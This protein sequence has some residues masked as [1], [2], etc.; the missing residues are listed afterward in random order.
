[1]IEA[2]TERPPGP[3]GLP[4]LGNIFQMGNVDPLVFWRN[5]HAEYGDVI[6]LKL[7]PMDA[8]FFSAPQAIYDVFVTQ[9]RTMRKGIG[10]S[11]LRKLLGEGL[12]TNDRDH[13]SSQRN[14]LNPV[15][16][17]AAVEAYAHAVFDACQAGLPELE[18]LTAR[19]EPI[20]I[21]HA[22]TRFTMRVISRAAFGVDLGEGHDQIVDAFEFAFAFVA[23]ITAQPV[24]P[25]LFVPTPNNR[26]FLK[27][28]RLIDAFID[29]LIDRSRTQPD[30]S[31]MNGRI[32][33]ALEGTEHALFRDEVISLYFAGFETTARTMTF[34]MDLLARH[35]ETLAALR[36]EAGHLEDG[37]GERP[38]S[39]RL[40]VATEIVNEALRIY[41]PVALMARQPNS[42]CI[43]GGYPVRANSLIIVCPFL[44]QR[45]PAFW[46]AGGQFAPDPDHP[47]AS[48]LRHRAAFTPFGGGPRLCLGKHFAMIELA[49]AI[50]LIARD[51]DWQLVDRDPVE[52]AFHGTLRPKVPVMMRFAIREMGAA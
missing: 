36:E 17:P 31:G 42:D 7:G 3:K 41:P 26:K 4:L 52:L 33:S 16:T 44:A 32:F 8:W 29:D 22:M 30:S 40:P 1:M 43:I 34:M 15:F 2:T 35:P 46:S 48:R 23:D 14:K 9:H 45:N 50:A 12:I 38:V 20:D 18:T 47:L 6:K 21:G 11:G 27:A 25:P 39:D 24:R 51:F 10:Y 37:A 49:L 19:N 13:W 5:A 28:R